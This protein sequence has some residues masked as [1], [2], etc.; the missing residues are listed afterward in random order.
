[1]KDS[2]RLSEKHGVNPTLGV[3]F[4]CG[5]DTG[6][7]ALLGYMGKGDPEAPRRT[8]L[9]Y[10]PCPKCKEQWALGVACLEVS[11]IP[12]QNGQPPIQPGHYPTGHYV[13]I[14]KDAALRIGIDSSRVLM[15]EETF[16]GMFRD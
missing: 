12:L 7:I 9:S 15:D 2:I 6:E 1:M 10:D 11:D 13:V 4:W 8:V 3:C 14:K 5:E 16:T